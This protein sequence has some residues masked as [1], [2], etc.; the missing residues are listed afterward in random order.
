MRRRRPKGAPMK[1]NG[2]VAGGAPSSGP[3]GH[4]PPCGGKQRAA[5]GGGSYE[6]RRGQAPALQGAFFVAHD[7]SACA[8][9][10]HYTVML[11]GNGAPRSW[12]RPVSLGPLGQFT[13]SRPTQM[14]FVACPPGCPM[15]E[16]GGSHSH[17]YDVPR[18]KLHIPI[19]LLE[20]MPH[21][22][23]LPTK[24]SPASGNRDLTPGVPPGQPPGQRII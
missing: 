5:E 11:H 21:H 9:P 20:I 13:F 6:R 23:H 24:K 4:L 2:P 3:S 7:D 12:P 8:V 18:L 16:T 10:L 1:N 17:P 15:R 19:H 14:V 22:A